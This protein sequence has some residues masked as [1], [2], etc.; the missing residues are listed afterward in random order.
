MRALFGWST[1][2][3]VASICVHVDFTIAWI[4]TKR[5]AAVYVFIHVR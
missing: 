5:H 4:S 3:L 2:I 1:F